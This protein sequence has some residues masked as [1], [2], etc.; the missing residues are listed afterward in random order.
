VKRGR[1]AL[2]AAEARRAAIAAQGFTGRLAE[3]PGRRRLTAAFERLGVVQMDSV[4]VLVR[5]HYLPAFS[6]LG[7]YERTELDRAAYDGKRRAL[8]EYWAHEASLVPV[9]LHPLLRWRMLRA[10]ER[11]GLYP[12]VERFARDNARLVER[13]LEE[14]RDHGA[15]SAGE[16]RGHVPTGE[17]WWG[18]SPVKAALEYLFWCGDL[19]TAT[20][21]NFERVY[22]LPERVLPAAVLA[23]PTPPENEAQRRLLLIAARALGVA[24][25]R[26]LRDYF[27]LDTADAKARIAELTA[28]GALLPLEVEGWN[29]PGYVLPDLRIP[30]G[31][32]AHALLSPFDSLVW[33]RNRTRQL[34]DFDFR[35]EIYTPKHKR[36]HGYYVLPFLFGDRIAARVDLKSR[37]ERSTLDAIAIHYE[38][39]RPSRELQ[40]ALRAELERLAAWLGLERVTRPKRQ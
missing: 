13:T 27:R 38:D 9:A 18:W 34:F 11:R 12:G 28:A 24:T 37:R 16:M 22:D 6:R 25:E 5:S 26:D 31:A 4:N 39:A 1:A 21:R 35:L 3:P 30:R 40:S 23:A 33:E 10:R 15:R 36:V 19:T 20:R 2:S 17:A 8:F 29:A 7:A 32:E 14:I